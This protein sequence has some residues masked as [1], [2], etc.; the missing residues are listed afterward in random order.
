MIRLQ[1]H[2]RWI[3]F[4]SPTWDGISASLL[5]LFSR[6][7]G[8]SVIIENK[9]GQL[10]CPSLELE[11]VERQVVLSCDP[12]QTA[13]TLCQA[14]V[15]GMKTLSQPRYAHSSWIDMPYAGMA[16]SKMPR[17]DWW[18]ESALAIRAWTDAT[19]AIL[20]SYQ[21]AITSRTCR[22]GPA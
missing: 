14:C 15:S 6:C 7:I 1:W 3:F 16:L 8:G 18:E 9:S 4:P 19:A 5:I 20:R 10:E 2:D 21:I 13:T 11:R 12:Y 22:V 17:T